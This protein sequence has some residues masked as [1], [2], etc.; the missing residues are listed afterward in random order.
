MQPQRPWS[1]VARGAV[2]KLLKN[3]FRR[4][5]VV[6]CADALQLEHLN[7]MPEIDV[8]IARYSYGVETGI[9]LHKAF[10]PVVPG[11]DRITVEPDGQK[12]V[13]RMQWYVKQGEPMDNRDPVSHK[14]YEYVT[15]AASKQTKFTIYTS[16]QLPPPDR[17]DA[18]CQLLCTLVC[19][20]DTPYYKL[21]VV[22]SAS[23]LRLVDNMHL[24][25]S[26]E[27]EPEWRLQVGSKSIDQKVEE[28][29]V[30]VQFA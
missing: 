19:D 25:M 20:Y 5:D 14:F 12:R 29:R 18:G 21:P 28:G 27:G 2:I 3:T 16:D 1:A 24:T 26:F 8:R 23:G 11:L 7:S 4:E 10:P 15:S 9:P 6:S 30:D 22:D 13:W 17:R